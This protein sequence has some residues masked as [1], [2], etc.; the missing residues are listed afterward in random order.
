MWLLITIFAY[1]FNSLSLLINKFLLTKKIKNSAVY[2][3]FTCL[4]MSLAM[5]LLPF[6]WRAPTGYEFLIEVI[7]G[8][9][10][11][12]GVYF[13]FSALKAGETSRVI[14][15]LGGIQ[16][17]IVLPVAWFWLGE[18]VSPRFLVAL[19]LIIAGTVLIS[20]GGGKIEKRAY[21]W[22]VLSA[23]FFAFSVVTLK[24]A[25][26]SQASFI[27]PFALS[28]LGSILLGLILLLWPKNLRDIVKELKTPNKQSGGLF[29]VSQLAGGLSA[30]LL[31][32]AF[33]ISVGVTALINALQG[34]QYVFLL[35]AIIILSRKFPSVL[36]EDIKTKILIQKI[37]A[38]GLIIIGLAVVAF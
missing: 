13:M 20:Y 11:G 4:L 36:K 19:F 21:W 27:T 6:D 26:N 38:T 1:A 17:L 28:R 8:F 22:S 9:L 18:A 2:A 30:L 5:F 16:P 15:I 34:L 24:A 32:L 25:F 10:F 7:S 35:L 29:V 3:I 12:L 31:N 37:L 33:A 23:L 14:P